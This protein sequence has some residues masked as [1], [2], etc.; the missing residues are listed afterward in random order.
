[1]LL[2][3]EP[4]PEGMPDSPA[5]APGPESSAPGEEPA[6]EAA[7][8]SGAES[9]PAPEA[10]PDPSVSDPGAESDPDPDPEPEL[11]P[12]PDPDPDPE[13]APESDPEP[14]PEPEP[15]PGPE[16][17]PE[18]EPDPGPE[19]DPEPAPESDPE[20]DPEPE[21]DPGP[22]PDPEP[23][24]DPGP[25]PDPEP[26]PDPGPEP[27]PE[28]EPDPDPVDP[29]P[30]P[31]GLQIA[32]ESSV[33]DSEIRLT[34]SPVS[35]ADYV[36]EL[37]SS[38]G[39]SNLG[40]FDVAT[41]SFEYGDLPPGRVFARVSAR[42]GGVTGP[43]SIDVSAWFIDFKDY[44]EAI[45]LGTGPLTPTDGNHGCSA[46]GW[47]RGFARGSS[48]P[49]SVSTTVSS[50][51]ANAISQ[52]ANQVSQATGGSIHVNVTQTTDPN[53]IPGDNEA[54]STTHEDA[55]SQG[56]PGDGGC[57]IHVFVSNAT[58]G[59]YRSSRAIQPDAQTPNAYAHDAVGHGV[60]GLCHVDGNL[61]G[62]AGL[63]LMSAG[64]GV[65]SGD[66]ASSLSSYDIEATQALYSVG[67]GAGARHS[68]LL[69]AGLI[70]P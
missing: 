8:N 6:P 45:F 70:N 67:L 32:Y 13:P 28:P 4:T 29:P 22:E 38:A 47:V 23:E 42:D 7:P 60:V 24:P 65:F 31:V 15:D 17:D 56:C 68:D 30:A 48:V 53:P 37:G 35:G 25:E 58:P 2:A 49:L 34:W 10:E 41:T 46:T 54:T 59:Q 40:S 50:S 5:P 19:P 63:S 27:D 69:G 9:S 55:S 18:P 33:A 64:P 62:G 44:V 20:P 52:A 39:A 43:P 66:I 12:G 21:P 11:D 57:T 26:E 16:P 51:K 36:V 14:D 61:I 1:M 3:L